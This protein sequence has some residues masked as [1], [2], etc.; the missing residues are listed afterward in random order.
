MKPYWLLLVLA[1]CGTA[2]AV[3]TTDEQSF[4]GGFTGEDMLTAC[5]AVAIEDPVRDFEKGICRGFID[6]FFA[7]HYAAEL[8]HAF[9]HRNESLDSI[10]GRMCV[11][12]NVNRNA[13]AVVFVKYL[14]SHRENIKWNAGLLLE[15]AMREA[16]PCPE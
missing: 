9:H 13:I 6:G 1:L 8:W 11:P 4:R 5:K 7:G 10:F 12:K 14:E 15:S 16:F 2:G 3:E